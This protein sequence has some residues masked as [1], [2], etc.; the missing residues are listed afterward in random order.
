LL[1]EKL[2]SIWKIATKTRKSWKKKTKRHPTKF[3]RVCHDLPFKHEIE[4]IPR[5]VNK[6]S[7]NRETLKRIQNF[8]AHCFG[9]EPDE[10]SPANGYHFENGIISFYHGHQSFMYPLDDN[11]M[12]HWTIKFSTK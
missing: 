9:L 7:F 5:K 2:P 10:K 11:A 1:I 3:I 8:K 12:I 4:A 6:T